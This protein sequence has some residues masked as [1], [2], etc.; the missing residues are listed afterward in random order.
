MNILRQYRPE[1]VE[2][3]HAELGRALLPGGLV[4][5]GSTDT[6]GGIT[7]AYLLRRTPEGLAREALLFHTD[8][9]QGFAPLLFRDWLPRDLRR[10]VQPE[11]PIH[12]F[13]AAWTEPGTRRGSTARGSPRAPSGRAPSGWP[14]PPPEP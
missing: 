5:E 1:D 8:F 14:P 3:A 13:F 7:V 6:R 4:V 11:E 9:H 2:T 12:D 10:R